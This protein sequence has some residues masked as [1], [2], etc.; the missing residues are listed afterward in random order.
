MATARKVEVGGVAA[1]ELE[2]VDLATARAPL[3]RAAWEGHGGMEAVGVT[4]RVSLSG[5]TLLRVLGRLLAPATCP[6]TTR[7]ER[8]KRRRSRRRRSRS[9]VA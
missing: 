1:T 9:R 7:A 5:I 6:V 4:S 2:R 3:P 8:P